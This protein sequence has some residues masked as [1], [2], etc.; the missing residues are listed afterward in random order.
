MRSLL[1]VRV[2]SAGALESSLSSGPDALILDLS[3]ENEPPTDRSR[4]LVRDFLTAVRLEAH[5]PHI[6]VRLAAIDADQIDA[7]LGAVMVGEPDGFVLGR[8]R[9]GIDVQHLAAKL[10]VHE[11]EHG[12]TDGETSVIAEAGTAAQ[13]IFA[14]GSYRDCS[15]RLMALAWDAGAFSSDL[16]SLHHRSADLSLIAPVLLARSLTLI[17]ARAADVAAIDGVSSDCDAAAFR[18]ECQSARHDGFNAKIA[19][20]PEQVSIINEVFDRAL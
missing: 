2:E 10:A 3:G 6:Y 15:P 1:L 4:G 8:S 7:D 18:A 19:A 17:G 13:A 5:R 11:A 12:L 9:S 20:S 16:G 14:M